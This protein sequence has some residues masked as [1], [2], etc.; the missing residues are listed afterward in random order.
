MATGPVVAFDAGT[1]EWAPHPFA[2]GLDQ[3]MLL[4]H[5]DHGA[6][7]TVYLYRVREVAPAETDDV[8][9]HQHDDC[10]DITFVLEGSA[11]IDIEGHGTIVLT[12]DSFVRVPAGTKHRVHRVSADFRAISIFAPPRD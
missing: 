6:D 9:L 11:T 5:R 12:P 2:P 7:A 1:T 10:D 4:S 3:A 8:P